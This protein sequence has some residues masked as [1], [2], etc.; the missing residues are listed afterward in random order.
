M[1]VVKVVD[2]VSQW[3]SCPSA[4]S[5]AWVIAVAVMG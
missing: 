1:L 3:F 2:L 4:P 5:V